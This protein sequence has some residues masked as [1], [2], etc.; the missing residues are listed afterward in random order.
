MEIETPNARTLAPEFVAGSRLGRIAGKLVICCLVGCWGTSA[1]G[2]VLVGWDNEASVHGSANW[3]SDYNA[4]ALGSS[5]ITH[6]AGIVEKTTSGGPDET[7]AMK[8]TGLDSTIDTFA[9][10]STAGAYLSWTLASTGTDTF[11]VDSLQLSDANLNQS[12][13]TLILDLRSSADNYASSLGTQTAIASAGRG[14]HEYLSL[15]LTSET[16]LTFRLY[17]YW[18]PGS[19]GSNSTSIHF[20]DDQ[21]S[22]ADFPATAGTGLADPIVVVNGVVFGS[23]PQIQNFSASPGNFEGAANVSLSWQSGQAKRLEIDDGSGIIATITSSADGQA[24]LDSGSYQIGEV[25]ATTSY[26]LTA[27]FEEDGSGTSDSQQVTVTVIPATAD[28]DSDEDGLSDFEENGT[29]GTSPVSR[30]TDGDGTPDGL[31][32][33]KGLDPL[34]PSK[35]LDRPNIIFFFTD[36]QGYGDLGCFWQDQR[37]GTRK[38]DTPALDTI[39][40]EGAK[41]THHYVGAPICVSSRSSIQQ[42]RHQG[43][44]DIRNIQFD[45]ALPDNHTI[46]DTLSRAGYRTIHIGKSGIAG[47]SNS[48]ASLSGNGSQDLEAHPLKRGYDEFFGYLF[49]G[50]AHEHY[51]RN[52]TTGKTAHIYHDY[53][54]IDNASNDLYTTDAWTAYAK[55]AIEREVN[56]GDNQPFF[57]YLA[58][59]APHFN[60][61]RPAVAYPAGGGTG[62]GI[63]WTTATDGSGKTRY[64]STATGTGTIDGFDHPDN[65]PSWDNTHKKVVGMIR[66]IDDSIGDIVQQLKDLG[67]DD[68]TLLVFTTDN[69]PDGSSRDPTYFE[70]Y[71]AF[72]GFK[73]D[74]FEGGIRVPTVVRWPGNIS[75]ATGNENNIHEIA[76][77]SGTW[78]WMPTFA[79]MAGVA[80]PAWCDGVSLLP[81]LTGNGVQR[82]KGYLYI[83]FKGYPGGAVPDIPEFPNHRDETREQTQA[84]RIGNYMGVRTNILSGSEP[85]Q[86]YDVTT[87]LAQGSDLAAS[88]SD[89]QQQMQAISLQTRRPLAG[90]ARPYDS[91]AVP[92]ASRE[93]EPGLRFSCYEGIWSYL[94]EFRD[95]KSERK[96]ETPG[97]D[98]SL[99]SRDNHFGMLFTGYINIETAGDHSFYVDSDSGANLFIH[100]AHVI[101][102]DL[103]HDGS[104]KSGTINLAAGLHPFRLYYR[105]GT[106]ETRSLDLSWSGPGIDKEI[107]PVANFFRIPEIDLTIN[108]DGSDLGFVWNSLIGQSYRMRASEDLSGPPSTWPIIQPTISPT[109]PVNVL[110]IARPAND[111]MF[112]VVEEK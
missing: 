52:G 69:G 53:Q 5:T 43:H 50:D 100:D 24:Q 21:T 47:G 9:E 103:V 97:I 18:S 70:S 36:D 13:P 99:R 32:V 7:K 48:V 39:A 14:V 42:G 71:A 87:D 3:V 80:G 73:Q 98:L 64:A 82:D 89:L 38:F 56:D 37:T 61:Q 107:I 63:Q 74:I 44:S 84:V 46:A 77:P 104:E 76:Y 31:E 4:A 109:P 16:S 92:N 30:D 23:D 12:G 62:G 86:I 65:D 96:G 106:A 81:T 34:D 33:E 101:D 112:Y 66:R 59:D 15:G 94:P 8:Y 28:T 105:H 91:F 75:G 1:L 95:L 93:L 68:N 78:D 79:E 26:T 90:A 72:E 41:M 83:E 85:F 45:K 35:S 88:R 2:E 49:H 57:L 102:D 58:Y 40:A 27:N 55:D 10:A 19:A 22:L 67:I 108:S 54:Q 25:S 29:F 11:G 6:G 110:E 20:R 17:T 111:R 60:N 51:P